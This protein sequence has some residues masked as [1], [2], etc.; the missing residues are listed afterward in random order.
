M[1]CND[2]RPLSAAHGEVVHA[3]D[4]ACC[5]VKAVALEAAVAQDLPILEPPDDV[6]DPGS[7]LPV[8]GVVRLLEGQ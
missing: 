8:G 5:V 1:C 6:L 2:F 7:D 4:G 3:G